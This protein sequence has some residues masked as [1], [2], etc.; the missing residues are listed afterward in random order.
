MFDQG[1]N[2]W[3]A[4]AGAIGVGGLLL[5]CVAELR[6]RTKYLYTIIKL[7]TATKLIAEAVGAIAEALKD[8]EISVDEM[9]KIREAMNKLI[10]QV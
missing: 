9:E 8:D 1:A 7:A 3:I 5:Y 10:Q 2:V 4:P 6:K